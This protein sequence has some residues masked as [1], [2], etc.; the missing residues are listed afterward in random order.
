MFVDHFRRS[1]DVGMGNP[2][3]TLVFVRVVQVVEDPSHRFN[4][5]TL[6]VVASH[7]GPGRVGGVG[8]LIIALFAAVYW[9]H[10][11]RE[12]K[13]IGLSFHWRTGSMRRIVKRVTCSLRPTENQNLNSIVSLFVS[14]RSNSGA[15]FMNSSYSSSEQ[16]PMTRSTPARL[17]QERSKRTISPRLVNA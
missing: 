2:N 16:K 14:M 17:Y 6:L 10:R 7:N 1:D 8:V 9:S 3:N 12:A 13:S 4:T 15:C 5:A 11:S